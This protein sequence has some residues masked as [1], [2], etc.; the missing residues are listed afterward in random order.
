MEPGTRLNE[1]YRLR[2]RLGER[3]G[4]EVWRAADELFDRTVLVTFLG[5]DEGGHD[6]H[7][8]QVKRLAGLSHPAIAAIFDYDRT[9]NADG[10]LASFVVTELPDGEDLG[11][12][13]ERNP[14]SY[15]E[16]LDICAR[17]AEALAAAHA[18]GVTHGSLERGKIALTSGGVRVTGFET[19]TPADGG[20]QEAADV[21]ALGV[22][23]SECLGASLGLDA[24]SLTSLPEQVA[25]LRRQCCAMEAE[26]RPSAARVA[27]IL[28]RAGRPPDG[29]DQRPGVPVRRSPRS[30]ARRGGRIAVAFTLL[31]VIGATVGVLLSSRDA[32]P[33]RSPAGRDTALADRPPMEVAT[34]PSL[35]TDAAR[36]VEALSGVQARVYGAVDDGEIRSDVALDLGNVIGNLRNDLISNQSVD[37]P[38]RIDQLKEKVSTRQRERVLSDGLATELISSLSRISP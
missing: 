36:T 38:A 34:A 12:R 14:P 20:P 27:A 23:L 5:P 6:R 3:G 4:P 10:L 32:A 25:G 22:V 1:R 35:S 9:R 15:W 11:T 31:A 8:R 17:V 16:A 21:F 7:Q 24:R 19:G 30:P 26:D 37:V 29:T 2:V 28:A 18:A 33:G 13:L